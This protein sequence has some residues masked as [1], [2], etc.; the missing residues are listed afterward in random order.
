MSAHTPGPWIAKRMGKASNFD[1][2]R[3]YCVQTI[4]KRVAYVFG[5][6]DA[7][8]DA[9]AALVAA[10]PDMLAAL[11]AFMGCN[12]WHA[13]TIGPLKNAARAAIAKAEGRT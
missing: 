3:R 11:R 13:E 7:H 4:D 1:R 2:E 12:R 5:Q 6:F 10:A 9:D 8:H